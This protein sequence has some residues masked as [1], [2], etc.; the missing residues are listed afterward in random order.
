MLFIYRF[1][2]CMLLAPMVWGS[3]PFSAA[4][5]GSW[6]VVRWVIDGDTLILKDGRRVRYIGINAPETAHE[7]RK[8]EPYANKAR[9]FNIN[10]V[11][12][13]KVRLEY[14]QVRKDD[15]GRQ[16]AYVYLKDG[17][18]VNRAMLSEGLAYCYTFFPNDRYRDNFLKAQR[19]AM[20]DRNGIWQLWK[21]VPPQHLIGNR[22][23]LRFFPH[24]CR[25]KQHVK[26]QAR[27]FFQ[28]AWEA[29]REGFAPDRRCLAVLKQP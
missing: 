26:P 14:D 2:M 23:S 15:Y 17:T 4:H 21:A 28:N 1:L 9:S 12:R 19:K 22:H 16:L 3:L 6:Y 7:K 18:F 24:A 11:A 29:F 13:K 10:L 25:S 8:A 27:L 20:Q 5:A